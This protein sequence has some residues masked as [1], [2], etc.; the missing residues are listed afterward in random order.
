MVVQLDHKTDPWLPRTPAAEAGAVQQWGSTTGQKME[1]QVWVVGLYDL[2][3][4][5]QPC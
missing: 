5:F 4:L 2:G 3:H 1:D